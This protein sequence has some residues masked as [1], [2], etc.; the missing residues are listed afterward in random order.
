MIKIFKGD[1]TISVSRNTFETMYERLGYKEVEVKKIVEPKK[2]ESK[3]EESKKT[4]K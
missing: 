2:D 1:H 3:K 4:E